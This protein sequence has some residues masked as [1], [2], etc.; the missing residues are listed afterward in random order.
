MRT[1]SILIIM[2]LITISSCKKSGKALEEPEI[3]FTGI[4]HDR[5]ANSSIKD[6]V[7]INLR[8]SMAIDAVGD[9]NNPTQ[10]YFQD[11]RDQTSQPTR[12]PVEVSNNLPEGEVNM[13]GNITLRLPGI[14]FTLRPTRPNGDTL[15][16][17]IYL[18]DKDNVKS[19]TV[20]TPDIYILP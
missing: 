20:E 3:I 2:L 15:H 9:E 19:N 17:N 11:S 6:T 12:F 8:Y 16:Y 18:E 1:Y 13:S 14:F 7:I 10:V 5:I 4:S